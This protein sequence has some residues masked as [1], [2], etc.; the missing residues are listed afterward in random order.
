M[1]LRIEDIP[2]DALNQA[3]RCL[4]DICGVTLAG[5]NTESARMLLETAVVTYGQGDCDI[6]GT[7]YR[8]NAPGAAFA[9]GSAAHALDF[10]DNCY[11]GIVHASAVVFPAVLAM[12][13]KH[14]A[15]GADLL[16]GFLAGIEVEF[17]VAKA[18]SNSI[19]DR[20]WW[21]TSVLG[22]I[23]SAAGVAKVADLKCEK[24]AH[25]LA[26]AA[27][28]A[29]AVRAVRGTGAKH[30]HCGRAS[31]GGVAAAMAAMQGA[32]GPDSVFED[33]SG[34]AQVLNGGVFDPREIATLGMGFSISN[35]G[36]DLKK[37]PVCYASHATADAVKEIMET[38][39]LRASDVVSLSCTVPPVVASN[40]TY[41]NPNTA[42]EA[43]FS[44]HFAVAAIIV[45]GDIK[46]EHLTTELLSSAQF[47]RYLQKIELKVGDIP[48]QYKSS[49]LIC[50]E[51]GY[52]ELTT[53]SGDRRCS[54]VGSPVGS[55]L[56]PMSDEMLQKKFNACVEY[57]NL[58][59]S[60]SVLYD[61]ILNIELLMNTRD[62]FRR[63]DS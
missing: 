7:P 5:A 63:V 42:A 47:K 23:G 34:I 20:G 33:R 32:T 11:A 22:A 57:S 40:L 45:H 55:A 14:G 50:P 41:P 31:E 61:K 35:P 12:A 6:L 60:A 52:V 25:A 13:Q 48:E 49:R 39:G 9:N 16:L 4:I 30:F 37:Y 8:L 19:Y 62:L 59:S 38:D 51:W 21:T 27:A 56:R 54:F 28:G 18:L 44:L 46:L 36:I 1:S 26:L 43:Q 2:D 29:G 10:D 3:K 15:S 24:A 17:A 58:R 53:R